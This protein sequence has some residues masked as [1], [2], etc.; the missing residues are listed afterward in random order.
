M[1]EVEELL[2]ELKNLKTY[3]G[4]KAIEDECFPLVKKIITRFA[5]NDHAKEI[6]EL[7]AKVYAYEKIIANSNFAP[8]LTGNLKRTAVSEDE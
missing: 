2:D 8:I 7:Q 4:E 3:Y 5:W 1:M 6:A